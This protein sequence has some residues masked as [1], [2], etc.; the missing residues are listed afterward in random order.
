MHK[1]ITIRGRTD[2]RHNPN[3]KPFEFKTWA[4]TVKKQKRSA[5]FHNNLNNNNGAFLSLNLVLR[6]QFP[7]GID[8]RERKIGRAHQKIKVQATM[9]KNSDVIRMEITNISYEK[10]D[11]LKTLY[12]QLFEKYGSILEIGRHH[13]VHGGWFNGRGYAILVKDK[14]ESYELLTPQISFWLM[15]TEKETLLLNSPQEMDTRT[16]AED[17]SKPDSTSVTEEKDEFQEAISTLDSVDEENIDCSNLF[18]Q[19]NEDSSQKKA[20]RK[21]A[22]KRLLHPLVTFNSLSMNIQKCNNS[23]T[24]TPTSVVERAKKKS[25]LFDDSLARASWCFS[26]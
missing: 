24:F 11:K 2:S 1:F 22:T 7:K 13:T 19:S 18:T 5:S 25:A 6:D 17:N 10:D 9:D 4:K 15:N 21:E 20:G 3:N 8:P 12:I 23:E 16:S 14:A 26:Q